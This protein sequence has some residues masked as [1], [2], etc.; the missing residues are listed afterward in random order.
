MWLPGWL[1]KYSIDN[2]YNTAA[3][4][5]LAVFAFSEGVK[6]AKTQPLLAGLTLATASQRGLLLG[7]DKDYRVT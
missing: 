4:G 5:Y 2:Q 7:S 6:P 3:A 1:G